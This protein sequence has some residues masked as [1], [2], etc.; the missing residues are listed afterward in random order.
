VATP[1]PLNEARFDVDEIVRATGGTVMGSRGAAVVGVAIDSRAVRRGG[2]FVA[3]RGQHL[4]GHDFLGD[5]ARAGAAVVL[6]RRGARADVEAS[7]TVVEVEDTLRAL[8]HLAA[9]HRRRWPGA[10]VAITGSA[11]KT[12]TKELC[13]AALAADGTAVLRSAG[14]LNNLVG[15]PM[16]LFC[17]GDESRVAVVELGSSRPGEIRRLTEMSAP[18]VGIVTLV[19]AAHT[20]GL[21]TVQDVAAE[22]GALLAS[23]APDGTA[24]VNAD[25]PLLGAV[26]ASASLRRIL[27]FGRAASADVRLVS[28]QVDGQRGTRCAYAVAGRPGELNVRLRMLGEGAALNAA[29]ALCAVLAL[30]SDP[31]V[32]AC[33]MEQVP[34]TPGRMFPCAGSGGTLLIDD[35]YNANPRSMAVALETAAVLARQLGGGLVAVLGDMKELGARSSEEHAAVGRCVVDLGARILVAC[36]SEMSAAAAEARAAEAPTMAVHTVSDASEATALLRGALR[37]GDVVLVKGSRSMEMERVV[38]ALRE[39]AS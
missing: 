1:V 35:T 16:T 19:A 36:G 26:A 8:G 6:V 11:G 15:V 32:A 9:S 4:D 17:L 2:L 14:N 10:V 22:K 7:V 39:G 33:A 13:A 21:G 31:D 18:D 12:G 27:R 34:P 28:Q 25:D 30:G 5:A 24:V 29:A 23:M 37:A 20:E 3:L 38:T